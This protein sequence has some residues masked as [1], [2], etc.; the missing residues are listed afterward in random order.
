ME[1]VLIISIVAVVLGILSIVV[2]IVSNIILTKKEKQ[3]KDTY[4]KLLK[5]SIDELVEL[6]LPS[7]MISVPSR[8]SNVKNV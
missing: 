4:S 2:G 3:V 6:N 8:I 7:E 1:T 5:K